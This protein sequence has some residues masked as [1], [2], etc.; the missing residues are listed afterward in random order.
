MQKNNTLATSDAFVK[1]CKLTVCRTGFLSGSIDLLLLHHPDDGDVETQGDF[2]L[3]PPTGRGGHPRLQ[4]PNHIRESLDLFGFKLTD[5][6]MAQIAALNR[7][8][9]LF[10]HKVGT[11]VTASRRG[12]AVNALDAMN[13]SSCCRKCS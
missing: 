12:S 5:T 13:L 4:Q 7:D 6:K 1:L 11:A 2:T 9:C 8:A 3:E 10:P